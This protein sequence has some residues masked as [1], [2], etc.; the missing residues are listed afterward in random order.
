MALFGSQQPEP[1]ITA[2]TPENPV[3][4]QKPQTLTVTGEG[5]RPGLT[6]FLTTPGG[7]V[8]T[9]AGSDLTAQRATSFQVSLTLA[10]IG[11]YSFVVANE[12]GPRSTAFTIQTRKAS[13]QP[14][15]EEV[16]P[17]EVSRSREVQLVTLAGR[18]FAPGLRA[19]LT[20]PSGEV[21]TLEIVRIESAS[22]V[23]RAVFEHA[24]P[25]ELIVT[26]AAGESSNAVSISVN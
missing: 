13:S 17:A 14:W 7:E 4:A 24:G 6:L 18:N 15:I 1:K 23:L 22:V 10:D 19:S 8:K 3:A 11:R 26:N 12:N 25:H 2:V 5:F 20:D 16:M 9:L 21:K